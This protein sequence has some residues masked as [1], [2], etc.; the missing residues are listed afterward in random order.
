MKA[1]YIGFLANCDE[2]IR[3]I[4]LENNFRIESLPFQKG[5]D[6][7]RDIFKRS[8]LDTGSLIIQHGISG[9]SSEPI[10]YII[11]EEHLTGEEEQLGS[12]NQTLLMKLMGESQRYCTEIVR[13]LRLYKK[14]NLLLPLQSVFIENDPGMPAMRVVEGL[15]NF[16]REIMHIEDSEVLETEEFLRDFLFPI[17]DKIV[18]LAFD[19][20]E[21]SY[22]TGNRELSFI[23]CM[24]G[25]EA[26]LNPS[27][28]DITYRVSRNAAA[29][30][31]KNKEHSI[32][33]FDTMK[34]LYVERSKIVHGNKGKKSIEGYL[35]ELRNIL[36]EVI[37]TYLKAKMEKDELMRKLTEIGYCDERAWS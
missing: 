24:V 1:V 14:G 25:I 33:I 30:I 15:P 27:D 22:K 17:R 32:Y 8:Q 2:T 20:F 19:S 26:L 21:Q 16:Y 35:D 3:K 28:H 13:L 6:L 9:G 29:L 18:N 36:R 10:Y 11:K 31:G 7:I 23:S 5:F 4:K 12:V 37:K 34:K